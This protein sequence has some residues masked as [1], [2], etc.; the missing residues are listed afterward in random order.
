MMLSQSINSEKFLFKHVVQ[1]VSSFLFLSY[2]Y[3]KINV[4]QQI[5]FHEKGKKFNWSR[6][7]IEK[8]EIS[9]SRTQKR[10]GNL[11]FS[12][13]NLHTWVILKAFRLLDKP[14]D[15]GDYSSYGSSPKT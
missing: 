2:Q 14:R 3:F 9:R 15:I 6:I 10:Y 1:F 13:N 4:E 12:M 5:Y 7:N 11:A 8:I